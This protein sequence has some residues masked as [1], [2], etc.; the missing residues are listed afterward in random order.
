MTGFNI[1]ECTNK[2]RGGKSVN[3]TSDWTYLWCIYHEILAA[4]WFGPN[5]RSKDQNNGGAST[6]PANTTYH[7]HQLLLGDALHY[8]I[9]EMTMEQIHS[10]S[11]Y[12]TPNVFVYVTVNAIANV[13]ESVSKPDLRVHVCSV[14]VSRPLGRAQNILIINSGGW[15]LWH[16]QEN[17]TKIHIFL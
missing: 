1:R 6:G 2:N 11:Y 5:S 3:L 16:D 12:S 17:G 13:S 9:D 15:W 14:S 4:C 10:F 8:V 7:H